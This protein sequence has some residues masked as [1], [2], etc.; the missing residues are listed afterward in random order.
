MIRKLQLV[1]NNRRQ[2]IGVRCFVWLTALI[3]IVGTYFDIQAGG[4]YFQGAYKTDGLYDLQIGF[5][6]LVIVICLW[7]GSFGLRI[8][9]KSSP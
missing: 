1:V 5:Q 8:E 7:F 2:L 3:F 9:S 6:M 4:L